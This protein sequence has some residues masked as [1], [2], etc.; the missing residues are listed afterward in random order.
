MQFDV[1]KIKVVDLNGNIQPVEVGKALGNT[2]YSFSREIEWIEPAKAIHANQ[3]VELTEEQLKGIRVLL[4]QP[5]V[6]LLTM[7]K[8]AILN[9]INDLLT[10]KT[11]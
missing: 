11:Q 5:Y 10:N 8:D 1:N 4:A 3:P 9:Y 6:L 7:V 2:I